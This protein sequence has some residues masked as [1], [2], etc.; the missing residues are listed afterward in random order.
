MAR[1][2][3]QRAQSGSNESHTHSRLLLTLGSRP[4]SA[5][6][7]SCVYALSPDRKRISQI[8]WIPQAT[9]EISSYSQPLESEQSF[10]G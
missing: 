4:P 6:N 8:S 3:F 5:H 2:Q 10:R 1:G 9:L 7:H